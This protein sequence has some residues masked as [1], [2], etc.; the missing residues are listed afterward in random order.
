MLRRC[1][2]D[3]RSGND[4]AAETAAAVEELREIAGGRSDLLAA[5][6]GILPGAARGTLAEA[7]TRAAALCIE[8]GADET[9]IPQWVEEERRRA[10]LARK[11]RSATR[12]RALTLKCQAA[13]LAGS[14]P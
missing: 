7:R 9:L 4:V 12:P 3:G 10:E 13:Y 8:A 1:R 2:L 6:A 14:F 11:P 5:T